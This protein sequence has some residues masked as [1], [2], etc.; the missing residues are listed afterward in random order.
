M[1]SFIACDVLYLI[2][3][4]AVMNFI[5]TFVFA[6]RINTLFNMKRTLKDWVIATR[7]WSFPASSMSVVVTAVLLWYMTGKDN[8]EFVWAN[9]L[10]A[11]VMMVVFQASGNLISDYYD[12][13][14]GVDLPGS[15]NGV[16]HIQSGMF[17]PKEIFHY[18]LSLLAISGILGLVLLMCSDWSYIWFGV[19]GLLLAGFYPWLKYHACGDY[20]ILLCYAVLPS[21][22]TS[23]V[24]TGHFYWEAVAVCFTYGLLTVAILHANNTRDIRNDSRA[25][26]KTLAIQIGARASQKLYAAELV[27]PYVLIVVYTISGMVPVMALFVVAAIPVAVKNIRQMLNAEPEAEEPIATLDQQTAQLQLMFSL[28]FVAG[29]ICGILF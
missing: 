8:N 3:S 24:C 14:R 17:T 23:L 1:P 22:G 27:I 28:L 4:L 11:L 7:P 5:C 21:I 9:A 20:D 19:A 16:R 12:H 2:L 25:G 26:I 18:G 15:L 6:K 10:I 29:I 13:I